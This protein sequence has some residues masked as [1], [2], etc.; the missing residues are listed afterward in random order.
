MDDD[1]LKYAAP[2]DANTLESLMREYGQEVWNYAYLICRSRSMADDI[3][4]DVFLKA[5]RHLA[6]FR[7]EASVK[8]WL[9]R[10]TRNLSYNY[11]NSAFFRKTLLLD[12]IIPNGNQRSAEQAFLDEEATNEVWRQV[13]CLSAKHREVLL[14][15]ARHQLSLAEIASLLGVPE[16]TV[17]SRLFTARQKLSKL[18][19][20]DETHGQFI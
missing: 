2:M 17:K 8:T 10:I 9:L 19:K 16:G 7:G 6:S 15:H 11:R 4:Q 20:E 18:L 13:F 5:Y 3:T 14:L 1:Y 12:V